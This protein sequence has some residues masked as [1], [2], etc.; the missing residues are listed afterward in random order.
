MKHLLLINALE[1]VLQNDCNDDCSCTKT[2]A[3]RGQHA[4]P[5]LCDSYAMDS[6]TL[7][8]PDKVLTHKSQLTA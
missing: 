7:F 5:T 3:V 4:L 2:V 1:I 6:T 8:M